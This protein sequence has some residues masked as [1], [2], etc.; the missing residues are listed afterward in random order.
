MD[1]NCTIIH[2]HDEMLSIG[3]LE[4]KIINGVP[5]FRPLWRPGVELT[6]E[7]YYISSGPKLQLCDAQV[8]QFIEMNHGIRYAFEYVKD[9]LRSKYN[10]N[11]KNMSRND[12]VLFLVA[13]VCYIIGKSDE[14][15]IVT[16]SDDVTWKG[17]Y[18]LNLY[19]DVYH[20]MFGQQL[21]FGHIVGKNEHILRREC[22]KELEVVRSVSGWVTRD[23]LDDL[24]HAGY[25]VPTGMGFNLETNQFDL[26]LSETLNE[27]GRLVRIRVKSK[28]Y[29]FNFC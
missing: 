9:F 24:K 6:V 8:D 25:V 28:K 20:E 21:Y 13:L 22:R 11:P 14:N 4:V 15:V 7:D 10:V 3:N 16:I 2:K 5:K 26:P 17:N 19:L 27:K 18:R 1:S 12:Y 29:N 23:Q